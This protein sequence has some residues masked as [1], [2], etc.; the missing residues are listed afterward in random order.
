MKR[1]KQKSRAM[2]SGKSPY[3]KYHKAPCVYSAA[4]YSWF[5]E[6]HAT[7]RRHAQ[8]RGKRPEQRDYRMAA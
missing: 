1:N 5:Q 7:G 2:K 4:Y 3:S 6:N 8:D